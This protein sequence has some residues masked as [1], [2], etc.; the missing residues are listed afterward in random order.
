MTFSLYFS[1]KQV[2][3]WIN[4]GKRDFLKVTDLSCHPVSG[5]LRAREQGPYPLVTY[6]L[7]GKQDI[8]N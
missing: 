2:C 7:V 3:T 6:S 5:K 8:K 4:E 1:S